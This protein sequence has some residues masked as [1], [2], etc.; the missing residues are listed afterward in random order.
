ML[1]SENIKISSKGIKFTDRHGQ[2][3]SFSGAF[4]KALARFQNWGL[5]FKI[6][7][8]NRAGW[9]PF[10]T[11]RKF[12]YRSAGLEI[13]QGSK[14]HVFTRFFEPGN[15]EIGNDSVIG[16]FGFLDGRAKLKIG[17]HVSVASQVL[18]YNSEHNVQD[19]EFKAVEEPVIIEDYVFI[20]A[21]AIILPGVKIGRGAIVASGAVVT[22][23]VASGK[24]VG[25]VPAKEIGERKVKDLRYRLGRTRLFQ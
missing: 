17:D 7:I 18:I 4:K 23:D 6:L 14:I 2:S 21:R 13:G 20:G 5:D 15:I 8:V 19:S 25:G 22:K 12:I 16:E 24:I 10:W 3:L 11:F 1:Y 9:C